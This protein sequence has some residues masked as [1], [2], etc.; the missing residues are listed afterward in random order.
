MERAI[1]K[2]C[3]INDYRYDVKRLFE[4]T[5]GHRLQDNYFKRPWFEYTK[6]AR[7]GW[8]FEPHWKNQKKW[9]LIYYSAAIEHPEYNGSIRV[10][11]RHTR[12]RN[13]NFGGWKADLNRGLDTLDQ[14][15]ETAM[16]FGYEN[17]W[18]SREESPKLLEYFAKH[19]CF[20]WNVTHE[21]LHWGGYQYVLRIT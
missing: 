1:Y 3:T 4:K 11:S 17:I 18:V 21:K 16:N 8:D 12:D 7:L 15:T 9:Y 20:N 10:M 13:Y 6:F 19:S 5:Y 14:L 2:I